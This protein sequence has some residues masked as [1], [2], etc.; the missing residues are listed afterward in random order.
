M[1]RWPAERGPRKQHGEVGREGSGRRNADWAHEGSPH[2]PPYRAPTWKGGPSPSSSSFYQNSPQERPSGPPRKRKFQECGTP[3]A[4]PD[5]ELDHPKHP[6]RDVPPVFNAPRGFGGRPLSLRDKSR[7]VKGR[8]MRAESVLRLKAPPPRPRGAEEKKQEE[9]Q[10]T[11]REDARAT[12]LAQRKERF[13]ANA[14]PQS[15]DVKRPTLRQSPPNKD[16]NTSKPS[17]DCETVKEQVECRRSL[18][19]HRYGII[20]LTLAAGAR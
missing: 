16:A 9:G 6:R 20:L 13:Q 4:D 11:A 17:R 5:L 19:T 8:K 10:H 15:K 1:C 14:A 12:I 3:P 18:S 7:I 2:H